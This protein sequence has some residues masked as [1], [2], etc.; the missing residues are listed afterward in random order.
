MSKKIRASL[1]VAAI[2]MGLMLSLVIPSGVMLENERYRLEDELWSSSIFNWLL[3]SAKAENIVVRALPID[4]SPGRPPRPEGFTESGY[5]DPSIQIDL[6]VEEEN[7]I[8]WW[9][10]YI[11]LAHASQLRTAT[12]GSPRSSRVALISSMAEKNN[13]II[14][15]NANY[16]A[17][18]PAKT[19]FEYRMGEKIRNKLNPSK[20]TLLTDEHGD[21]FIISGN[22][23]EEQLNSFLE[24]GRTIVNAFTF[25]PALVKNDELQPIPERYSYNPH[26]KEPRLALGQ[27]GQLEYVIVHAEGRSDDSKGATVAE[28]ADY[29]FN[30]GCSQAFNFDGGNSATI[31]YNGGYFQNR[32]KSNERAQ[33]DMIYFSTLIE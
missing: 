15:C 25:G 12:A 3:P 6:V 27:I 1:L 32:T 18:D 2:L 16:M 10:A 24:Q 4:F 20:D 14:A 28:L 8:R 22:N 29:M 31:T 33:S 13:A 30:M 23:K 7:G 5:Q 17:N 21:F 19:S 26:R 11:K 9:V